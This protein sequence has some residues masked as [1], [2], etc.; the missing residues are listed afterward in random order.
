MFAVTQGQFMG[1]FFV[2]IQKELNAYGF[3]SLPDNHIHIIPRYEYDN[4]IKH[5]VLD[6]VE[7][8]PRKYFKILKIQYQ[9]SKIKK[10]VENLKPSFKMDV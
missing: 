2:F 10:D 8:V 4:G 5:H 9:Q 6:K 1:E 7:S 3:L